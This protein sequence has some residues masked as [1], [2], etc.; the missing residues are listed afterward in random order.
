[1]RPIIAKHVGEVGRD[2]QVVGVRDA[3]GDCLGVRLGEVGD[4]VR[5][6]LDDGKGIQPV[7]ELQLVFT[8]LE[9]TEQVALATSV[10]NLELISSGIAAIDACRPPMGS[11]VIAFARCADGPVIEKRQRLDGFNALPKRMVAIRAEGLL[12]DVEA[13]IHKLVRNA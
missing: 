4:F 12:D 6:V 2:R 3:D 5:V 1:M 11:E 7:A 9:V 8:G 13:L 10:M